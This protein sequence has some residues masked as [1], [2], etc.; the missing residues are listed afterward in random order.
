MASLPYNPTWTT[1]VNDSIYILQPLS[2]A[3]GSFRFVSIGKKQD[4]NA[5]NLPS[6]ILYPELSFLDTGQD[7][8][9]TPTVDDLGRINLFS[10]HCSRGWQASSLWQFT[11]DDSSSIANGTWQRQPLNP[12]QSKGGNALNGAN[13]LAAGG[14]FRSSANGSTSL[15]IFGGMCPNSSASDSDK[16]TSDADYS[17]S[18]LAVQSS[19]IVAKD[20]ATFN[21][22]SSSA[23]G[24]PVAEAGFTMTPLQTTFSHS[25]PDQSQSRSQNFV[26]IGG[27]TQQAFINMSQIALFSLPEQT[28]TYIPVDRPSSVPNT[29]L[30]IRDD[31]VVDPRSGHSAILASDGKRII[32]YGGWVGDVSNPANPQ[33][34][35]LDLG[36]GF[37]GSG[38]WQWQ[39]PATTGSGPPTDT[40]IFGH[41]AV[42]VASDIMLIT[43]GYQIPSMNGTSHRRALASANTASFF[44]NITSNSWSTTYKHVRTASGEQ[45]NTGKEQSSSTGEKAGLGVGLTFGILAVIIAVLD[46]FWYNRRLKRRREAR[47][48]ELRKLAAG[49][50]RFHLSAGSQARDQQ[51]EMATMSS[52]ATG[53]GPYHD[54]QWQANQ[55]A[56]A[57]GHDGAT[58]AERTGLLFEIPSPTRGLRRSLHS[59]A[60]Y[61]PTNRFDD[62]RRGHGIGAIH[63]IDERDEYDDG[64]TET[65]REQDCHLLSNVPVLDPFRDPSDGARTP[66]P[67]S[68]EERHAEVRGW[69]ED[70]TAANA[71]L[72]A[73]GRLSPE[74]TDRTSSTLSEASARS[75]LSHSSMQ[76][77]AGALSRNVSQRS[78]ALFTVAPTYGVGELPHVQRAKSPVSPSR[79]HGHRRSK[80]LILT[81][82]TASPSAQI[83]TSDN[84]TARSFPKLQL[85]SEALLGDGTISGETSPTKMQRARGWMGSVRRAL[86]G[87]DRSASTSPVSAS[88]SPTARAPGDDGLPRRAASTGGMFWQRRQG[89][90]DWETDE[91]ARATRSSNETTDDG[92]WDVESA[93][94]KRVVQVMFTV[95]KDKLRV[96]NQ[97]PEE[98]NKSIASSNVKEDEIGDEPAS[99]TA[100]DKGKGRAQ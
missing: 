60:S 89:Q 67:Q 74:R 48:E 62:G 86:T 100:L 79:Y 87:T 88:S 19:E 69:V 27:H 92:D 3:A 82:P 4:L 99:P 12:D 30:A 51:P 20:V 18:M 76:P 91:A 52:A 14:S 22:T 85:E 49:A 39:R 72:R 54:H 31:S 6:H 61:Q 94:E 29:D 70:W 28:W 26:L 53:Q 75:L 13:F 5:A 10:G 23:Q 21:L 24:A 36:T 25:T 9:I 55:A 65:L 37:G 50:H 42:M 98:D 66:S 73:G 47:E 83:S 44:L 97:G 35:I 58:E 2:S 17:N 45:S 41:G 15:F 63:P 16:W 90:R 7:L 33:L 81:P 68:P 71:I 56:A 95:P 38:D 59:R 34:A 46:N 40:G 78:G 1:S 32:V 80:S 11:P 64:A 96:V 57:R 43:G 84:H 93:V 8:A 77:S